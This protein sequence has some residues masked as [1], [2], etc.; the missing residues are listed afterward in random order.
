MKQTSG[1]N[2]VINR[3]EALHPGWRVI[4][5]PFATASTNVKVRR[6]EQRQCLEARRLQMAA[7]TPVKIVT[8]GKE[9]YVLR[10]AAGWHAAPKGWEILAEDLELKARYGR[11]GA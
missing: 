11:A 3:L 1:Y 8:V 9:A 2:L 6:D 10:T 7:H 5:G 4:A